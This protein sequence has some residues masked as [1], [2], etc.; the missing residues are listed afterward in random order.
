VS[1]GARGPS[2]AAAT[3]ATTGALVGMLVTRGRLLALG[4]LGAV[5]VLLGVVARFA[6]DPLQSGAEILVGLGLGVV[7]PVVTLVIATATLG[8][9]RSERTLVYLWLR[10]VPLW[11]IALSSSLATLAVALPLVVVPV[12]LAAVATGEGA[13][14]GSGIAGA[15]LA[16]VGYTGVFVPLGVGIRRSFLAGLAYILVW[17]GL[18]SRLGEGF[19]RLSIQSYAATVVDRAAD[20]GLAVAGRSPTASVIVPVLVGIAGTALAAVLLARRE[21]D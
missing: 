7:A 9:L 8:E 6:D 12:G 5:V 21:I 10:P 4:G 13:L 19:A 16:V 18:V 17:E 20:A 2:A 15:V 14:I 11:T 1:A 3:R